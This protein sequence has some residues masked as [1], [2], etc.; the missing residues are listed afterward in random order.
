M[1]VVGEYGGGLISKIKLENPVASYSILK[2]LA[3]AK[4]LKKSVVLF[5]FLIWP[6][7]KH[8][9]RLELQFFLIFVPRINQ[10]G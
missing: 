8:V 4:I 5:W 6:Y 1:N 7:Y 3:Q 2:G 10:L 9:H